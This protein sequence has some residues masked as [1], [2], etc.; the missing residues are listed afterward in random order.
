MSNCAQEVDKGM[1]EAYAEEIGALYIETSAKDDLNVHDMFIKLSK[2][3][4]LC[5]VVWSFVN[6][7]SGFFICIQSFFV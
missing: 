7:S 4:I 3:K 1:A 6:S 2:Q 5:C